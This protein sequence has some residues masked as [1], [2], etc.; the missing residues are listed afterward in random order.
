ML[1]CVSPRQQTGKLSVDVSHRGAQGGE[2]EDEARQAARPR[3]EV[4]MK[5]VLLDLSA[6][7]GSSS[8]TQLIKNSWKQDF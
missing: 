6:H 4:A 5:C 8:V 3:R 1:V 7:F 2:R